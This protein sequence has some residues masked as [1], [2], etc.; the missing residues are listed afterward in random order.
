MR[1]RHDII[2]CRNKRCRLKEV[3]E[4]WLAWKEVEGTEMENVVM[5]S[6]GRTGGPMTTECNEFIHT[7][8]T[9]EDEEANQY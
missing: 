9:D 3:C 6:P 1:Y 2:H 5:A 7:D 8:V 4:R